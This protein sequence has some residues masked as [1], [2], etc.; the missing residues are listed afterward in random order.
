MKFIRFERAG[1]PGWGV[2]KGDTVRTLSHAPYHDIAYDGGL[3]PR[4]ECRLLAPCQPTKIVCVGK[5]YYDHAMEMGE[6][7]PEQPLLFL[8]APNTVN[9]HEGTVHAPSFVQRLC[10]LYFGLYLS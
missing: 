5:N 8:K 6:G 1:E 4:K 10:K 3:L 7:V 9:C 2:L